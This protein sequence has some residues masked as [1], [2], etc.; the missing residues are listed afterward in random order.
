MRDMVD[1]SKSDPSIRETALAIVAAIPDKDFRAE[2]D[3]VFSF[4]R[5]NIRYT[6]DDSTIEQIHSPGK[7]LEI[8]QGDCDDQSI[9]TAAL[10]ESI[11]FIT[12]FCAV[13]FVK[14]EYS[15]V[16]TEALIE[17][18][19][20]ALDTTE[21]HGM[22]WRPET[23]P[24]SLCYPKIKGYSESVT[25]NRVSRRPRPAPEPKS[26]QGTNMNLGL[27]DTVDDW[28]QQLIYQVQINEAWWE[29]A[30]LRD[31][32]VALG[33]SYTNLQNEYAL[34]ENHV[35]GIAALLHSER[36]DNE[37]LRSQL[38]TAN[39]TK[40]N[41]LA[42]KQETE[43]E[44][45]R[46]KDELNRVYDRLDAA[47]DELERMARTN[48]QLVQNSAEMQ[49]ALDKARSD[50]NGARAEVDDLTAQI[51]LLQNH[52]QYVEGLLNEKNHTITQQTKQI[53]DLTVERDNA[54]A[55]LDRA[56]EESA[57]T[58]AD[59]IETIAV[60]DQ[61]IDALNSAIS[62]LESEKS[63]LQQ[64][65]NVE[66]SGSS[67][68]R[69]QLNQVSNDLARVRRERDGLLNAN[70]TLRHQ[71]NALG[72]LIAQLEADIEQL[73][74]G[75][76]RQL[77]QAKHHAEVMLH[78]AN[79]TIDDLLGQLEAQSIQ[80]SDLIVFR[81]DVLPRLD[82]LNA[83]INEL[84]DIRR[85]QSEEIQ[86][87]TEQIENQNATIK[88]KENE[89]TQTERELET[90][91]QRVNHL[92][93]HAHDLSVEV[94]RLNTLISEGNPGLE[95]ALDD[96]EE[97][98]NQ[99]LHDLNQSKET[100][101]IRETRINELITEIDDL[102]DEIKGLEDSVE[103]LNVTIRQLEED[104]A[105]LTERLNTNHILI[106]TYPDGTIDRREIDTQIT[107]LPPEV[108]R[109]LPPATRLQYPD[110]VEVV[111]PIPPPPDNGGPGTGTGGDNGD[112]PGD[113]IDTGVEIVSEIPTGLPTDT[114]VRLPDGTIGTIV[115][116]PLDVPFGTVIYPVGL[117][118]IVFVAPELKE[119]NIDFP[120]IVLL[121]AGS[122][123][124]A[125]EGS[126]V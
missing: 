88:S 107:K 106:I 42:Q 22:G 15:H 41:L 77:E 98:L 32:I 91:R 26:S 57:A 86:R 1:A 111:I 79:T 76:L 81:D 23:M 37:S 30:G 45:N 109:Q 113:L 44:L 94:E 104:K 100:V 54:I 72:E 117:P 16:F 38:A 9:L 34:L 10:L 125:S 29:I 3:A 46:R 36:Y 80:L 114:P 61:R 102:D 59:Q 92:E 126:L 51:L 14:N 95:T 69:D 31:Q 35:N 119:G 24:F 40:D 25:G 28:Y 47:E 27:Y 67:A 50:L 120:W 83:T 12:R 74:E 118:P 101:Q 18:E 112:D 89:L 105:E 8:R 49:S 99:A 82:S 13:G 65:L 122:T 2:A 115:D 53:A 116:L 121:V 90:E 110:G 4:V 87:Q 68:L 62:T 97:R 108:L 55:E 75:D 123:Y 33:E 56:R 103:G 11:G 124:L 5:S 84:E 70:E 20:V 6:R 17:N 93:T 66:T 48:A 19:W 85:E 39:A 21:P 71:N 43:A 7:L 63:T 60:Q 52:I 73:R 96:A 78:E 58:I 64:R